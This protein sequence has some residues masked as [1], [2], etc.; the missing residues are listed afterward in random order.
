MTARPVRATSQ[1]PA[2]HSSTVAVLSLRE[3]LHEPPGCI[4]S[5]AEGEDDQEHLAQRL[6]GDRRQRTLA[7]RGLA[8]VAER[9]LEGE[10]TD[11]AVRHTLGNEPDAC[12]PCV[13]ATPAL[14]ILPR[15]PRRVPK[16]IFSA[17][18]RVAR[19]THPRLACSLSAGSCASSSLS[20]V[21]L[22]AA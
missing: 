21:R 9:K 14:G 19:R 8:A 5:E 17:V 2:G 20:S 4:R 22:P 1:R 12:E 18:N 11:D 15:V 3:R 6:V 13:P 16:L 7:A 10:Y